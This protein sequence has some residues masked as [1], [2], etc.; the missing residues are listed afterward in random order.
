MFYIQISLEF[1]WFFIPLNGV[2]VFIFFLRTTAFLFSSTFLWVVYSSTLSFAIVLLELQRCLMKLINNTWTENSLCVSILWRPWRTTSC[3][4]M[5]PWE[6]WSRYSNTLCH[7]PL[8]PSIL[9]CSILEKQVHRRGL[10]R[11]DLQGLAMQCQGQQRT[12]EFDTGISFRPISFIWVQPDAISKI[13]ELY[14]EAGSDIIGTNT[15]NGTRIP[16]SDYHTESY[17]HEINVRA[18][19]LCKAGM[20]CTTFYDP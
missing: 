9:S 3:S 8:L 10:Q 7:S 6:P 1:S 12:L 14:L 17:V 11:R 15:F 4:S 16:Q 5:V 18:A 13:H 2:E 20:L 19:Q